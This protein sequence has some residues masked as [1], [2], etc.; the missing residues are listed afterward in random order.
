MRWSS[1][2]RAAGRGPD[3][4]GCGTRCKHAP[5]FVCAIFGRGIARIPAAPGLLC[6]FDRSRLARPAMSGIAAS[7]TRGRDWV[8][9]S[10][11]SRILHWEFLQQLGCSVP[12][13][14]R[15]AP[16]GRDWLSLARVGGNVAIASGSLRIGPG[17]HSICPCEPEHAGTAVGADMME[18]AATVAAGRIVVHS[19]RA[20]STLPGTQ[21]ALLPNLKLIR[22]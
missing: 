1:G 15:F 2:L 10:K 3:S 7:D 11:K 9:F 14:D 13:G 19:S 17:D 5:R 22:L 21:S 18:A 4:S 16:A 20:R 6:R 8:R 12:H